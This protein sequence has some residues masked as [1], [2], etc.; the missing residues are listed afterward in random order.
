LPAQWALEGLPDHELPG[1]I[2][3]E[4]ADLAEFAADEWAASHSDNPKSVAQTIFTCA[5]QI[6]NKQQPQWGLAMARDKSKLRA[7][8][9]R[10]LDANETQF[11]TIPSWA[12]GAVAATLIVSALSIPALA[13]NDGS[14][15]NDKISKYDDG[16]TS[17]SVKT[18]GHNDQTRS[19]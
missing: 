1:L 2:A 5:K 3:H 7:R 6:T 11:K 12:K 17:I 13:L 4:V 15:T 10:L 14:D 8:I 18:N 9:D 19:T 16:D